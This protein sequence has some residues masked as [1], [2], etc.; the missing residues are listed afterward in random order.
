[1]DI[2]SDQ[3]VWEAL[4]RDAG[5]DPGAYAV[6]RIWRKETRTH[7]HVVMR[8][9]GESGAVILKRIFHPVDEKPFVTL[10]QAQARAA[11]AMAE[12]AESVP[13]VLAFD[14]E[15]RAVLMEAAP[16]RTVYDLL[17]HG[18]GAADVLCRAGRWLAAFHRASG[19]EARVFQPRFMRDHVG[20]LMRQHEAGEI[21]LARPGDF[22]R[23]G[24]AVIAL[25]DAHEGRQTLSSATH[26]DMHLRNILLDGQRSWGIDFSA[27]HSAPVGFDIARLLLHYTGVF[28][29]LDALPPGAVVHPDLLAAFFEGYDLV[30][31]DDP[32]VQYLLRVRLLMDWAAIPARRMARSAG[33]TRR[34]QRLGRLAERVFG[35]G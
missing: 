21:A 34:L 6:A 10:V 29:D 7:R 15:A 23:H 35:A 14:T 12:A 19:T 16:G 13:Q 33:Q 3:Q 25:A 11:E 28:A 26:G 31:P 24:A 4:A 22:A 1:M 30:G 18:A 2:S 5:L 20:H 8:I 32:S 17:D 9:E 27:L